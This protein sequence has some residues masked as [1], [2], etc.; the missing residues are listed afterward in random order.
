M[1][2]S[3]YR[4]SIFMIASTAV[5]SLFGFVFWMLAARLYS[6]ADIGLATTI[7]SVMG[8]ITGLSVLGLNVGL[9]RY[10]PKSRDKSNKINTC[11]ILVA[12]FSIGVATLYVMFISYFS[13]DLV[14]IKENAIFAFAFIFFMAFA[15]VG[16][17]I[18]SVFIAFRST[19]YILVKNSVFSFLKIGGLFL[20]VGLGAFGIFVS[21][22]LSLV[23][24]LGILFWILV[25]KFDY[26]PK[27]VFYD[28]I[29]KQMGKYSFG[30]YVAGFIGGL[31]LMILPIM[32]LNKLGA[33]VVAYYYMPMM[34]AG[35]LFVVPFAVSNSLFAEGS[36]SEKDL[37]ELVWK[38][39]KIISVLLIPGIIL[40]WFFGDLVLGLFGVE[41]AVEG[42]GLLRILAVGGIFVAVDSVFV[43]IL[44]IRKRV[45]VLAAV[46][47][48]RACLIFGGVWFFMDL[49]LVGIGYGWVVGVVGTSLVYFVFWIR[50]N[51]YFLS[52]FNLF[53]YIK[54]Y[55]SGE[56]GLSPAPGCKV[57]SPK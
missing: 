35:L 13:S 19:K 14:F 49:G 34:I 16:S 5:M 3:L 40:V 45:G 31:P 51:T 54:S 25:V 39:S 37:R 20:F 41:Y 29:I 2:D 56:K 48:F 27:L 38:A 42:V 43:K 8:L 18:D 9:I 6:T 15:G 46:N 24:A 12:L 10:L 17:L 11:F 30:N 23:V 53:P 47:V 57:N 50:N 7:I 52:N 44:Q 1:N 55:L 21:W 33:E 4:N 28:S 32:I 36:Y 22:M 26:K